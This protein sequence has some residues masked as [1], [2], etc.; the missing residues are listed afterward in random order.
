MSEKKWI[1]KIVTPKEKHW[2][3]DGFHVSTIF[4]MHSEDPESISPFLMMD[5]A[6]PK[7]FPPTDAKR[8]V[9]EHPH[10]GFETVT[11]AIKGEVEHRDSGGGG[12]T[13]KTGGIQWMTA[14]SGVVH[15]EF[16]SRE[17]AQ[18]GGDFEMIQ[19][20]VNL[21]S[22]FKMTEPRYQSFDEGDFPILDQGNHEISIKVIAGIFGTVS[23]K[24]KTFSPIN[25]YELNGPPNSKLEIP[26]P[27][28]SNTLVFQLSGKSSIYDQ[29]IKKGNLALLS[30][31]GETFEIKF[32]EESKVMILNGEPIGE[33]VA[34]YG[35][36]VM[37]TRQEL[38]E[39]FRDFQ[40]GKMGQLVN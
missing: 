11:F 40:A 24:V 4:S 32:L 22:K 27:V 7:Y 23:S 5:H 6:A 8:G 28:G 12:G 10:R 2:V 20:W 19:L 13:I 34:A 21:P 3:G 38:M 29:Q 15:D 30:K 17:F 26:L 37:N 31:S 33:P 18:K 36:F 39:A 14:G 16:H 35:P 25:M 1:E 9:G